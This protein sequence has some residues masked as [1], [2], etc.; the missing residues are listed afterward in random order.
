MKRVEFITNEDET[1][2]IASFAIALSANQ[3]LTLL[4]SPQHEVLFPYYERCGYVSKTRRLNQP[5][6]PCYPCTGNNQRLR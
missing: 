5:M 2:L 1:D 3:S 6:I 4:R